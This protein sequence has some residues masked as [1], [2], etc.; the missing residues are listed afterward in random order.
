M[1]PAVAAD[2]MRVQP[3]FA[4][5]EGEVVWSPTRL[6]FCFRVTENLAAFVAFVRTIFIQC[7]VVS[8]GQRQHAFTSLH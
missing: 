5:R 3:E 1:G 4:D 2:P 6:Q 8:D 7:C